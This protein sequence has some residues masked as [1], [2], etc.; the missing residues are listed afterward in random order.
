MGVCTDVIIRAVRNAG[1]DLQKELHEDIL[2]RRSAFPMI[3]KAADATW[4]TAV[5]K[6][7]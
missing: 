7:R 2:K 3:R 4:L 6:R 5:P 1:L